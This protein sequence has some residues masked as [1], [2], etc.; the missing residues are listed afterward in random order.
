M[1]TFEPL[2]QNDTNLNISSLSEPE[3][4][5]DAGIPAGTIRFFDDDNNGKP[6]M[7][8]VNAYGDLNGMVESQL[9]TGSNTSKRL[10]HE[11]YQQTCNRINVFRYTEVAPWRHGLT[12]PVY[13]PNGTVTVNIT[14]CVSDIFV[15]F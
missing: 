6:E 8:I 4:L 1:L 15:S 7:Y 14:G 10:Y 2:R 12:R 3:P 13:M 11:D 5:F 9:Y